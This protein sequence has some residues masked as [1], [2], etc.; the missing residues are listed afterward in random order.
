MKK[1]TWLA[2]LMTVLASP[3]A[4]AGVVIEVP[5]TIDTEAM[6]ASGNMKTARFSTNEQEQ[7]GCGIRSHDQGGSVYAW[8]F[9][10]ATVDETTSA[11]CTT[12][13]PDLVSKLQSTSD[14]AFI[15]FRWDADGVCR[16]I[17]FS[18]QSQYIPQYLDKKPK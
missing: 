14:Y 12:D 16:S 9:C 17:G 18:T 8:A 11:F 13:N 5:V 10:Q 4:L 1:R 7:I 15:T 2:A 3:F 6:I